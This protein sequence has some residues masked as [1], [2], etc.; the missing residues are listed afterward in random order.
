MSSAAGSLQDRIES[1]KPW[2]YDH[3]RGDLFIR[4][5]EA[6]SRIEQEYDSR[7]ELR[8]L[9]KAVLNGRAPGELRALDLGCLEG[10]YTAVMA[11]LGFKEVVGIDISPEHLARASFLL[12]E[13]HG[14]SNVRLERCAATDIAALRP[15]GPFDVVLCHGL[16]Y[17]LKDPLLMFD[18]FEAIAPKASFDLLLS[19][20]FKGNFFNLISRSPGAELQVKMAFSA[21]QAVQGQYIYSAA[22]QSVFERISL[23]LNPAALYAT[24][25]QYGYERIAS[26]D[27]PR[28]TTYGY[29]MNL[30]CCKGSDVAG[31][32]DWIDQIALKEVSVS[33]TAWDGRSVDGFHFDRNPLL[34]LWS[35]LDVLLGKVLYRL[36]TGRHIRSRKNRTA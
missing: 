8:A 27:T 6:I 34:R 9:L 5:D 10:H 23:R 11:Q 13:F 22:D 28:G 7:R 19:T 2:R 29:T 17:H 4:G 12:R 20:Q 32:L 1:L 16:L 36:T 30:L 15:L 14:L 33:A 26:L 18:V 24:L 31:G 3:R 35:E 21:S 25:R